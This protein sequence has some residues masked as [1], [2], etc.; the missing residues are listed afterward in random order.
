MRSLV[1]TWVNIFSE[2]M[3]L[4]T[5]YKRSLLNSIPKMLANTWRRNSDSWKRLRK[6]KSSQRI[7]SQS[8]NLK[9][10]RKWWR[11]NLLSSMVKKVSLLKP[12]D[13]RVRN[14][15]LITITLTRM[16]R[17]KLT[18]LDIRRSYRSRETSN[19][20]QSSI[21]SLIKL[22]PRKTTKFILKSQYLL[23]ITMKTRN[24]RM[25]IRSSSVSK[26]LTM[27]I[28]IWGAEVHSFLINRITS[29]IKVP[30]QVTEEQRMTMMN[31]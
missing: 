15:V 25:T 23:R 9:D 20:T 10:L 31:Q 6:A 24:N 12:N 30:M 16:A 8:T 5:L 14:T 17:I 21:K 11:K 13:Q 28:K 2:T 27:V 19:P 4:R 22:I 7:I 18:K 29:S 26:N 1:L 3:Q